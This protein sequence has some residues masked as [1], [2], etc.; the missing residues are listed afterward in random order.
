MSNA[1]KKFRMCGAKNG[2]QTKAAANYHVNMQKQP[3]IWKTY[4][5]PHCFCWHIAHGKPTKG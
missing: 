5:C 3:A 1:D 2:F 4:E